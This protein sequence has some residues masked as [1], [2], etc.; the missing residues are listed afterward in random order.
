MN[1]PSRQPPD[2]RFIQGSNFAY[3]LP[4]G[5]S[6]IEEGN[7]VLFIRADDLSAGV[8]VNGQSGLVIGL[9]PAQFLHFMLCDTMRV[10]NDLRIL[11]AWPMQPLPPYLQAEAME[12]VYTVVG[13][14]GPIRKRGVA[15]GNVACVPGRCDGFFNLAASDEARWPE[16][17]DWLPLVALQAVNIGPNPFSRDMTNLGIARNAQEMNHALSSY[18]QWSQATWNNVAEQ[19]AQAFARQSDGMGEV[20]TGNRWDRDPFTGYW[21]SNSLT[22]GAIWKHRDGGQVE[23]DNP[24]DD[25]NT[26]TDPNWRPVRR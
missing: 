15:V 18:W 14:H 8:F 5:W 24:T 6:R 16:Y 13:P 12:V 9:T 1:V 7:H 17:S 3:F 21:T 26:P 4:N 2:G 23:L 20:L 22:P 10:T 19:R 11:A 25:P